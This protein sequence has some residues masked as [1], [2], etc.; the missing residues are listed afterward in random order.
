PWS[1]PSNPDDW[2]DGLPKNRPVANP[3][4][5][6]RNAPARPARGFGYLLLDPGVGRPPVVNGDIRET[7]TDVLYVNTSD[8]GKS[9]AG[10]MDLPPVFIRDAVGRGAVRVVPYAVVQTASNYANTFV[11]VDA[12][13]PRSLVPA[14]CLTADRIKD[15]TADHNAMLR[16]SVIFKPGLTEL[17]SLV[18]D[19]SDVG[20][21]TG[22]S[23][24]KLYSGAIL[25]AGS[26]RDQFTM[27]GAGADPL[28]LDF[29]GHIGYVTLASDQDFAVKGR[30]MREHFIRARLTGFGESP[31]V[32][33]GMWGTALGLDASE[34]E[35]SRLVVQ[36]ISLI[37]GS[38]ADKVFRVSFIDDRELGRPQGSVTLVD[39][40]LDFRGESSTDIDRPL[41]LVRNGRLS[42]TE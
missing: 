18:T 27:L 14:E 28:T 13:G 11:A 22:G 2:Q 35:A 36:G 30:A 26:P 39:A 23:T 21:G 32:L 10:D 7:Q 1:E 37:G 17:N 3:P 15:A 19:L 16:G 38:A 31:L 9:M 41:I 6:S 20:A 29:V 34:N 33:S 8:L 25:F 12:S 4:P 5:Q 24:V 40:T 42:A